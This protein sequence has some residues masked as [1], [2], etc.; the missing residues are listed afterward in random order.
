MNTAKMR[1]TLCHADVRRRAVLAGVADGSKW[2]YLGRN[3][4]R[5]LDWKRAAGDRLENVP[6]RS[7]LSDVAKRLREPFLHCLTTLGRQHDSL[8]WWTSRLAERNPMVSDVFLTCCYLVAAQEYVSRNEGDLLLVAESADLLEL[9]GAHFEASGVQVLRS[10]ISEARLTARMSLALRMVKRITLFLARAI[11]RRGLGSDIAPGAVIMIRTWVDEACFDS[12][13]GFRD[14]YFPGL[15]EFLTKKSLRVVVLPVIYNIRRSVRRAWR[16]LDEQQLEFLN[17]YRYYRP[18]DY[19]FA[20]KAA[21]RQRSL[22]LGTIRIEGRDVTPLF[23]SELHRW[24]FDMGVLDALL[25]FRLPMRLSERGI[26]VAQLVDVFENMLSEK[27]FVLGFRR[28]MPGARLLAFQ[29]GIPAPMLLSLFVT[30]EEA[31]F[32]PLPDRVI[33]NGP[34]FRDLLIKGGLPE[35]RVQSGTALRYAYVFEQTADSTPRSNEILVTLPLAEDEAVELLMKVASAFR[36]DGNLA[37]VLKPH[38]M[39]DVHR[40]LKLDG[41]GRLPANFRLD[42]RPMSECIRSAGAVVGLG[43]STLF[44][45]LIAGVPIVVVGR[46]NV[47]DLNPLGWF[48][49]FCNPEYEPAE[50][51]QR[52][53]A[54]LTAGESHRLESQAR[55][56]KLLEMCFRPVTEETLLTFV[57]PE[58]RLGAA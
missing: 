7:L 14:R 43:S 58:V 33:C 5:Y 45:A 10:G 12:E 6:L 49:E 47:L 29:H 44:E 41:I 26:G 28:F 3:F 40:L 53:I 21:A 22:D 42:F 8:E 56:R 1:V 13:R 34:F 18:S 20:L 15:A 54:L 25:S 23:D 11:S 30:E 37:V 38:P 48:E 50:I 2:I 51:R 24:A 36:D 9:L 55:G 57:D 19:I 27:S 31:A 52:A 35:Q 4:R 32:A 16:W 17:E 46:D 39:S